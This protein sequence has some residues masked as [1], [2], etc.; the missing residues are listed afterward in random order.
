MCSMIDSKSSPAVEKRKVVL[1]AT[2][3]LALACILGFSCLITF[4]IEKSYL[5][6]PM[7]A[8]VAIFLVFTVILKWQ[9]GENL[10]GEIGFL[11]LA[12]AVAYT[13][14]P[15]FTFLYI[16]SD[17]A[18]WEKL[19]RLLPEPYRLGIHLWRHVLFIFGVAAGYLLVRGRGV[20]RLSATRDLERKNGRTVLFLLIF[21]GI[22][23]LC[24]TSMSAPVESYIDNYT[25]FD[26]LSWLPRK[27]VSVC[28]RLKLGVYAVLITFLFMDYKKYKIYIPII[29]GML[30]V[31]ESIFS[32]G[33][34]IES[35][36][37]LLIAF[38]LYNFNIKLI[39]IKKGLMTCLAIAVMFSAVELF[40]SSEFSVGTAKEAVS[41]QGFRPA[42]EFGAVYF[43]GFHLYDERTKGT[44]AKK[45]WPMFLNDFITLVTFSDFNQWNPQYW[46]ARNYFPDAVVPPETMGPIA[47][48]AIWGGEID[49][50]FR[51]LINGAFFAF[52]LRWFLRH[53]NKWWGIAI[54]VY[55]YATCILTLKYSVFYH[56][57][58]LSKTLLPTILV[59]GLVRKLIPQKLGTA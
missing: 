1:L 56:L 46:Y 44:L 7:L 17:L 22:C 23:I 53:R 51:S 34:R 52:I 49:L 8:T 5:I 3:I 57:A 30:C 40:R 25:R 29:V 20:T 27:I 24:I 4:S 55:C 19:A 9:V 50:F 13:L 59:L 11:Y 14:I 54:Y 39:S 38:G 32:F 15:A 58:P 31:Y 12:L 2:A 10:F 45:E 48:S 42:A 41:E 21:M 33:A 16:D 35:L 43:T 6:L 47:D 37:I 28:V 18:S 26:H 36:T